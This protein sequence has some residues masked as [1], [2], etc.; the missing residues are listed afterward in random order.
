MH[1]SESSVDAALG[2]DG[3]TSRGEELGD[4]GCVETGFGETEG[5]AQT[6]TAGTDDNRVVLMV[7]DDGQLID[8]FSP[9][10]VVVHAKS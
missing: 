4:A 1:V 8:L 5:G 6:G 7:L 9:A 3:V 10:G 2:G